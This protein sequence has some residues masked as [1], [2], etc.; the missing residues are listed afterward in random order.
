MVSSLIRTVLVL[1]FT[2]NIPAVFSQDDANPGQTE[3]K[4]VVIPVA[5]PSGPQDALNRG[6]PRGA[7]TGFLQACEAFDFERAAQY[8]DLR[9]VP[10]SVATIGGAELARRLNHILSRA[11]WLDDYTI[12]DD[13]KGILGDG[14]PTYRDEL[15]RIPT[16][17]GEAILWLQQVPREDGESIWKVSN[18]SVVLI[19]DLYELYSYPPGVETV[20][21][22][23]PSNAAFLGLELFKVFILIVLM[24]LAWPVLH[25]IGLGLARVF[26]SPASNRYPLVRKICTRPLVALGILIVLYAAL[27]ELGMGA[28][29]QQIARA[30]TLLTFVVV[31]I[32]WSVINLY[33]NH[34]EDKIAAQ[35]RP[36]AAKLV[37]PLTTFLKLT[38]L[39][40]AFLFWLQNLGV[41]ISALLAGLGIGGLAVALALQRPIE[42]LMGALSIFSQSPLRVG[43]LVRYGDVLGNVEDIGLRTTRLRTLTNTVVSI[44]NSLISAR[45]VENLTYRSKIRYW[46]TLRLRYDTTPEQ[47]RKITGRIVSMLESHERVHDDGIRARVTE[48]A[49]D[50]ILVSVHCF[51]KTIDFA[52]SLEIGEDLNFRIM[53]ILRA[54]GAAFALP[55]HSLFVE[56]GDVKASPG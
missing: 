24:L 35:G 26:S 21:G 14:L 56:G 32:I 19:P 3:T 11:V 17:D 33:R 6:T 18:R 31:W 13:P 37:R 10:K 28:R 46:P 48:F 27:G 15:V 29:A 53:E 36:G 12:S 30:H 40:V 55:S 47:L 44:P 2:A 50:A 51:M 45:E 20:R 9:N 39:L 34:Q 49:N 8:L 25:L 43:D 16:D 4:T 7:I 23:F 1:C 52:E 38:V 41:N 5:E 22:W 54:E 42:D